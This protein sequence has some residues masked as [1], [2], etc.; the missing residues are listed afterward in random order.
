MAGGAC[1]EPSNGGWPGSMLLIEAAGG[2]GGGGGG[3]VGRGRDLIS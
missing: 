1:S 3:L 2:G